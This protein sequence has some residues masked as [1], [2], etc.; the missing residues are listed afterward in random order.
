MVYNQCQPFGATPWCWG[1]WWSRA[2]V[3]GEAL[4]PVGV[5]TFPQLWLLSAGGL[6]A[7]V[8]DGDRCWWDDGAGR[9]CCLWDSPGVGL[10]GSTKEPTPHPPPQG[11]PV[12]PEPAQPG[13]HTPER[14][15]GWA[16]G[17][18]LLKLMEG[19]A[20]GAPGEPSAA[21]VERCWQPGLRGSRHGASQSSS[22]CCPHSQGLA[23]APCCWQPPGQSLSPP[24]DGQEQFG[25]GCGSWMLPG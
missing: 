21:L 11:S 4:C 12:C 22:N 3:S 6:G 23:R 10:P 19:E 16:A 25:H 24:R 8:A 2:G 17:E 7:A 14:M 9:S 18:L 15:L 13:H 1:G 20:P 5:W